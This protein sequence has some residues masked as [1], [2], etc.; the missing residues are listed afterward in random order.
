MNVKISYN[1]QF[2]AAVWWNN[3]LVMSTYNVVFNLITAG[4]N[5]AN[6]NISLD[7]LKYIVEEYLNDQVFVNHTEKEQI[8]RLRSAGINVIIMPEEPVDQIIG[9]MLYSKISAVMEGHMLVRSIMLS[10]TAGDNVIYEHNSSES[11][12]PFT[13][14]GWWN[15]T[16][17]VCE[18]EQNTSKDKIVE[19]IA[20]NQW[21]E[22][23][24]DWIDNSES[25]YATVLEFKKNEEK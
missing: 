6:T 4:I 11:L 25:K 2:M 13:E 10:S 21:R 22:L 9:M 3:S 23:G 8:N 12:D 18:D 5:P 20:G 7:R 16:T 24:L 1:T 15:A 17:P 19:I 14:P